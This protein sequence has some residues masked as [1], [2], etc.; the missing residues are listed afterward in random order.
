[1]KP[2]RYALAVLT[3]ALLV[4]ARPAAAGT[5][6]GLGADWITEPDAGA[7]QLTL[8]FDRGLARNVTLGGRVGALIAT[9]GIGPA[10]PLDL[11]LRF[12]VD[13]IYL[14]GLVG[15]WFFFDEGSDNV[16]LH[17][18]IGFGVVQRGGLQLGLEVGYVDP[19]AMIGVRVAW[20]F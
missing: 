16:R 11:R 8:A 20:P 15:P 17:A 12:R 3:L 18:A 13:R 10:V 5:A 7:L 9:D 4:D 19:S 2:L 6:I 1:M 14:D